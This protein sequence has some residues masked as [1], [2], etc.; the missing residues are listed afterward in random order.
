MQM[1]SINCNIDQFQLDQFL[2]N[3]ENED[4]KFG[5]DFYFSKR[6]WRE[7]FLEGEWDGQK[8]SNEQIPISY[9]SPETWL[10]KALVLW[11]Y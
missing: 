4:E 9:S 5:P 3:N 10:L 6:Q 2:K 1:L 8:M 7:T 11:E